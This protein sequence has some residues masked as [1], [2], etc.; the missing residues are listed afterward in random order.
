MMFTSLCK[1]RHV[2]PDYIFS[3]KSRYY[4]TKIKYLTQVYVH[5]AAGQGQRLD[6]LRY[7]NDET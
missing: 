6:D 5:S 1:I 3:H 4:V 2:L 7:G